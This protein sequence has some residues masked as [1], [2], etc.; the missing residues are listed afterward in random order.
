MVS[1]GPRAIAKD[2]LALDESGA[3]EL[4]EL[5]SSLLPISLDA[6]LS[7]SAHCCWSAIPALAKAD[8]H[9]ASANSSAFPSG[10]PM[11]AVLMGPYSVALIEDGIRAK[12]VIRFLPLREARWVTRSS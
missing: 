3:F 10:A 9:G 7:T 6:G 2:W 1:P 12:R 4:T 8:L 5:L 11:R